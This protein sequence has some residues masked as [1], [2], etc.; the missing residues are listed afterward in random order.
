M[1]IVCHCHRLGVFAPEVI[2]VGGNVAGKVTRDHRGK[3]LKARKDRMK[4]HEFARKHP[5]CCFCGGT[6][7]TRTM[8]HQPPKILFPAKWRPQGLEFPACEACNAQSRQADSLVAL[9]ARF[10]GGHRVGVA[11][12]AAIDRAA[13]AVMR[14]FPGLGGR[15]IKHEWVTINGIAQRRLTFDVSDP[16]VTRSACLVGAKLALAAYYQ[17]H[18]R[19]CPTSVKINTMW[20]H[21][22]RQEARAV[23]GLLGKTPHE[24]V[25]KQGS[26][27]T[28]DTFFLRY[29]SVDDLFVSIAVLHE[30]IALMAL[31]TRDTQTEAWVPWSHVWQP[32]PARGLVPFF[33]RGTPPTHSQLRPQRGS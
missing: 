33:D 11:P 4:A 15:A 1:E 17:H 14:A 18:K 22:Q 8:D 6:T 26:K 30:S 9:V 3:P 24:L 27:N 28:E 13:K 21:N 25:L 31:I 16:D 19:A 20:T 29:H 10:A 2:D 32:S 7:P 5:Y 12:D 23:E